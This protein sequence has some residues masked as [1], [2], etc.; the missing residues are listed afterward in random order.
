MRR[1]AALICGMLTLSAAAW[2]QDDSERLALYQQFRAEFDARRFEDALARANELV[3]ATESTFGNDALELAIPLTNVGTTAL[4]LGNLGL[5]ETSYLRSVT[6]LDANTRGANA[7]LIP[8]LHGLGLTYLAKNDPTSAAIALRRAVDLSRNLNGL[9]NIGQLPIVE[10]LISAEVA[11]NQ[12]ADAEKE[13]QYA[14][15]IAE[16]NYGA[17]DPRMLPAMANYA[18]WF[19][20]M[21][22][23]ST[24]RRMY[25]QALG[26][27]ENSLGKAALE[28]VPPLRGIARTYM[29]EFLLGYE[30]PEASAAAQDPFASQNQ[31]GAQLQR[32]NTDGEKALLIALDRINKATPPDLG[33]RGQT[34]L[35][36]GDWYLVGANSAKALGVYQQAWPDLVASNQL[37]LVAKPR[38]LAYKAPS[39][40]I[41]RSS[42]DPDKEDL[43]V[44]EVKCSVSETGKIG[45]CESMRSEASDAQERSVIFAAKKSRYAPRMENGV[46]VPT[47]GIIVRDSL[48]VAKPAPPK[49]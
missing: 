10:S 19:E 42:Y 33:L 6:V 3:S 9:Y 21:G 44:V 29:L 5:A 25:A 24:A 17:T 34:L 35:D 8:P 1:F 32:V 41:T 11:L 2:A 20:S 43:R 28:S 16:T 7:D 37:D 30:D 45:D 39:S 23:F 27:A 12:L 4:R 48:V 49:S 47:E 15:R 14:Y 46:T 36:L 26:V 38:Q 40:S 13:H 18:A 31:T 22:R